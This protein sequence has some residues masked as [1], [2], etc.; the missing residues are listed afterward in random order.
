MVLPPTSLFNTDLM[1]LDYQ[2]KEPSNFGCHL[3]LWRLKNTELICDPLTRCGQW[4]THGS[5]NRSSL[6][7]SCHNAYSFSS[8]YLNKLQCI[9]TNQCSIEQHS[10]EIL[11]SLRSF[12][13]EL[14]S[15]EPSWL[16]KRYCGNK[17][18]PCHYSNTGECM[19]KLFVLFL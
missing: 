5:S 17:L 16:S 3:Q 10:V 6:V 13:F 8:N 1:R 12:S 11:S 19:S 18:F 7:K 14:F 4:H 9:V 15:A 2:L